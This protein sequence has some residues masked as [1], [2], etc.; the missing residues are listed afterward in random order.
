[1]D[2]PLSAGVD[3]FNWS[4]EYSTFTRDSVG[5]RLRSGYPFGNYSRMTGVYTFESVDVTD[6]GSFASLFAQSQEGHHVK[7]SITAG[8][9]RDTTDHPF[10]PTRGSHSTVTAEYAATWLG[11]DTD[12]LKAEISSGWYI[13]LVWKFVGFLRGQIGSIWEISEEVP[14][15]ER[16][17]LGGI[18]NLRGFEWGEVGPKEPSFPTVVIP[19][20]AP[21]A[22]GEEFVGGTQ[23]IVGNVELLFPLIEKMGM[24]GVVFFDAGNAY[25]GK[26]D[27]GDV[28]TDVGTGIRWNSPLGPL[29]VELGYNLDPEPGEERIQ[30]QFSAGAFF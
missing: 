5:F 10:L 18:N 28:R 8:V 21:R 23:Y 17:F 15:F 1:M 19:G 24:R 12:F 6:V 7:S 9:E 2:T 26:W 16:F 11:S 4:R 14:I 3:L 20:T 13:P 22:I 30:W 27:F 29:R 25:L